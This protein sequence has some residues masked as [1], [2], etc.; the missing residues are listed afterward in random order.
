MVGNLKQE[1]KSILD[2]LNR[3]SKIDFFDRISDMLKRSSLTERLIF[4]VCAVA[5]IFTSGLLLWKVN[6]LFIENVP[7]TGGTLKEGVVG[8]PRFINPLLAVSN[9]DKDIAALVYS[10]L[11]K[12]A[13]D[14]KFSPD[15]A[16]EYSVS[17]DGQTY[18]FT[19]KDNIYFH[20][21]TPVTSDDVEFTIEKARDASLKSPKRANWEGVTIEKL[22]SKQINFILKQPYSSF[23]ENTTIGIIPKHIW[24]TADPDQ[25]TFSQ[26]NVQPIGSGPYKIKAIKR[27]SAGLPVYYSLIPF[28]K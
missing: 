16:K 4:Y 6:N 22:N 20:D 18:S 28:N 10:G 12:V 17:P 11:L 14:G 15:L 5:F 2:T 7:A 19:L 24:N 27:D 1:K 25:F 3:K 26:Y 9:A 8:I 13:P 21:G 23:L